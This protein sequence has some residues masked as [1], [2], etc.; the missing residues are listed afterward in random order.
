V[1]EKLAQLE[2]GAITSTEYITQ[3]NA[4]SR[5]RV[6]LEIRKIRLAQALTEYRT[7]QGISWN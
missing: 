1:A 5:A 2:Q 4:E 7:K 6:N 3:L